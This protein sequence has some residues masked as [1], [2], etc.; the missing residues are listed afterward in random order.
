[1]S[2]DLPSLVSIVE[3]LA[4]LVCHCTLVTATTTNAD[5]YRPERRGRLANAVRFPLYP[6][7]S[8]LRTPSPAPASARRNATTVVATSPPPM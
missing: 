2:N 6:T 8:P 5:A 7:L 4:C 3:L 1:M